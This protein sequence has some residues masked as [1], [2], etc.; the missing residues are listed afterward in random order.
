MPIRVEQT[1]RGIVMH[2]DVFQRGECGFLHAGFDVAPLAIDVVKLVGNFPGAVGIISEQAFNTERHIGQSASRIESWP[3][4]KTQIKR[5]CLAHVAA[6]DRKQ[7]RNTGMGASRAYARK[8]L[9][10]QNAVV[11][12]QSH[13]ISNSTQ[14]DQIQQG[15]QSGLITGV[16][17]AAL[18]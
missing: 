8:P 10:D 3:G 12:I 5:C 2:F 15:I 7:C 1:E 14:C 16:K 11:R 13:H 4:G 18:A 17:T 6:S 9:R